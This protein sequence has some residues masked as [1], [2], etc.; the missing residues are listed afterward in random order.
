MSTTN[1]FVFNRVDRRQPVPLPLGDRPDL[2]FPVVLARATPFDVTVTNTE[3]GI[4]QLYNRAGTIR[5]PAPV[6]DGHVVFTRNT[7]TSDD[8]SITVD[9]NGQ[10]IEDP[11]TGVLG[12]SV[13][14]TGSIRGIR[15]YF[16]DPDDD[17]VGKWLASPNEVA[18][19]AVLGETV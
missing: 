13:T 14:V 8:F 12:S 15:W 4:T 17:G 19:D 6:A 16:A 5:L 18:E 7:S 9:G 1:G 10:T 11:D 2:H 3:S